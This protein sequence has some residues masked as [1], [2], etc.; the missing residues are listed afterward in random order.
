ML[1]N[2]IHPLQACWDLALASVKAD[3]L[4]TAIGLGLF[5]ALSEATTS[6]TLAAR[7]QLDRANTSHLLEMLWSMGVLTRRHVLD[8][9]GRTW[10]YCVNSALAP[11]L[12]E[13]SPRYCGKALAYR[14]RALRRFG[15]QLPDLLKSGC[16]LPEVSEAAGWAQAAQAQIAQEQSAVTVG[17]ALACVSQLKGLTGLRRF[18]DLGGG[19]GKVAIA[20]AQAYPEWQGVVFDLDQTAAVARQ[21]IRQAELDQRLTTCCGDLVHDEIGYG[22]DLIWCSSVLHFVPDVPRVVSK[23]RDALA[24][25]GYFVSVHAELPSQR[26]AAAKVVPYYLPLLMRGRQ[27]WPQGTL[28]DLMREAGFESLIS[29]ELSYFPLAPAQL[30]IGRKGQP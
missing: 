2:D 21:G 19:P 7:L 17:A 6:D 26:E 30:L 5:A 20:L 13:G 9:K 22:Y 11:F 23:V 28:A 18:L 10:E 25:G 4:D 29:T 27:V 14:L 12:L 8:Q 15:A 24:P 16:C 3:A 1:I